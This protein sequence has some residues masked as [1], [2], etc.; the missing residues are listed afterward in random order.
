MYLGAVRSLRTMLKMNT[1][2]DVRVTRFCR[3]NYTATTTTHQL[4]AY[5]DYLNPLGDNADIINKTTEALS[6]PT[7][8]AVVEVNTETAKYMFMSRHQTRIQGNIVTKYS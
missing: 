1:Q 5:A 7:K 3:P 4:L 8:E 6:D 2:W